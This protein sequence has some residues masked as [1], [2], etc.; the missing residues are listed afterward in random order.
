LGKLGNIDIRGFQLF[1]QNAVENE[2]NLFWYLVK[3]GRMIER[4]VIW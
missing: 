1:I 2:E 3:P 4:C